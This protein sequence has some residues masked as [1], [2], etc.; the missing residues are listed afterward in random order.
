[1]LASTYTMTTLV[2]GGGTELLQMSWST[3]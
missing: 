1:M 3:K 2:Y